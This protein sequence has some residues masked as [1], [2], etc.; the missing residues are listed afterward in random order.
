MFR[1]HHLSRLPNV[2]YLTVA[3][4]LSLWGLLAVRPVLAQTAH[5]FRLY[6]DRTPPEAYFVYEATPGMVI[7][8]TV[9]AVNPSSEP[10]YLSLY[11]ADAATAANGGI[12]IATNLGE[13]PTGTGSWLQLTASEV[14]IEPSENPDQATAHPVPFTLT[15]PD[16]IAPGEYAALIVAQPADAL[17]TEEQTGPVGVRFIP[18]TATRV[19]V[20]IAGPIKPNLEI[21]A[22][23]AETNGDQ[24]M[25]IADLQNMGNAGIPQTEGSLTIRETEGTLIQE[26]PVRLGYFLAND[27]LLQRINIDPAL[28][29]REYDVTLALTYQD[30]TV[31]KTARLSFGAASE[32]PEVNPND[33]EE[34]R[35]PPPSPW[36]DPWLIVAGGIIFLFAALFI[37]QSRRLAR[38]QRMMDR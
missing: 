32:L 6:P 13:T 21:S 11:P 22:L 5:T 14:T 12:A 10:V 2:S 18:R 26:I 35:L 16:Q 34:A 8:D 17:N 37:I 24:Q 15:I 31:E 27:T 3:L 23:R 36:P 19:L 25:I 28:N 7:Q 29:A 9:L 33:E 38:A 30:Q 4:L 1:I 20:T